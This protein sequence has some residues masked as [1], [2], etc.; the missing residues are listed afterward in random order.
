M[1]SRRVFRQGNGRFRRPP[2]LEE[3]G[4]D[5]NK[6]GELLTCLTCGAE[7]RPVLMSGT[8]PMCKTPRAALLRATEPVR[9]E[10][11]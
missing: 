7:W 9:E 4:F 3:M 8:C 1:G 2:S 11:Q 5:V 6:G 10:E